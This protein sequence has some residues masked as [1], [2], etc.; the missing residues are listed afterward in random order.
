MRGLLSEQEDIFS[1]QWATASYTLANYSGHKELACTC[2]PCLSAREMK[3]H[4]INE[5]I[6]SQL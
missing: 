2:C 3:D 6:L 1:V 4:T 5:G